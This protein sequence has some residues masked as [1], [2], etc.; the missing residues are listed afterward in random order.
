[1]FDLFTFYQLK[2][3]EKNII[4]ILIKIKLRFYKIIYKI[5][6]EIVFPAA[7]SY[8]S[9]IIIV[10]FIYFYFSTF[11]GSNNMIVLRTLVLTTVLFIACWFSLP[12][13]VIAGHHHHGANGIDILLAT[14]MVAKL[15]QKK[16]HGHGGRSA[17]I[18]IGGRAQESPYGAQSMRVLVPHHSVPAPPPPPPTPMRYQQP[19]QQPQTVVT[20][21][22]SSQVMPQHVPHQPVAQH[23][24][25]H[26]QHTMSHAPDG[27][28]S[29][30]I[31]QS[32]YP[33][34][35]YQSSNGQPT[36]I[37]GYFTELQPRDQVE[38]VRM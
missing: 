35:G 23:T 7:T 16:K 29:H 37:Y 21:S 11:T 20:Y 24:M 13:T 1:M 22:Q 2:I 6:H 30:S 33:G 19:M 10:L 28:M 34:A 15:L 4:L 25:S 38:V 17:H 26:A 32:G 18:P 31:S 3:I 27:T 14:G 8:V 5:F 12:T 9:L 36:T